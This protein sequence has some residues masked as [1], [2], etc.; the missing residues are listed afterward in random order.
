MVQL[1]VGHSSTAVQ[2][3]N[4]VLVYSRNSI[5]HPRKRV[6]VSRRA[7]VMNTN[8]LEIENEISCSMQT[9][10]ARNLMANYSRLG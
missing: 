7:Q 6:I 5:G 2:Q 9:A 3:L 1:S 4:E 8:Y 10:F